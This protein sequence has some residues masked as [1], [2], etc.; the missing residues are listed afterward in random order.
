[1]TMSEDKDQDQRKAMAAIYGLRKACESMAPGFVRPP[2]REH[3]VER[4]SLAEAFDAAQA[5]GRIDGAR[6]FEE[7]GASLT[8]TG[9]QQLTDL[10]LGWWTDR[11]IQFNQP[12]RHPALWGTAERK[13]LAM[14]PITLVFDFDQDGRWVRVPSVCFRS[15]DF[16]K[17][18]HSLPSGLSVEEQAR[19]PGA[20]GPQYFK[21]VLPSLLSFLRRG[22]ATHCALVHLVPS[23]LFSTYACA[24]LGLELEAPQYPV[25]GKTTS[26]RVGQVPRSGLSVWS[27]A[28]G[29]M[30]LSGTDLEEGLTLASA[31]GAWSRLILGRLDDTELWDR[32]GPPTGAYRELPESVVGIGLRAALQTRCPDTLPPLGSPEDLQPEEEEEEEEDAGARPQEVRASRE[33]DK[34]LREVQEQERIDGLAEALEAVGAVE[35]ASPTAEEREKK[36]R[37]LA[38]ELSR[39]LPAPTAEGRPN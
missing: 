4:P 26:G 28:L 21:A 3:I 5:Q 17:V 19:V 6:L 10:A 20:G 31:H 25:T 34:I 39:F 22:E 33:A 38:R 32:V 9:A 13:T 16:A 27:V 1:M 11:L 37:E 35:S 12:E 8:K 23:G 24:S 30:D 36:D 14:L 2:W 15:A 7:G 18:C 29:S